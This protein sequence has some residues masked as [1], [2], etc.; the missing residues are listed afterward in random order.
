MSEPPDIFDQAAYDA[1]WTDIAAAVNK[2]GGINRLTV[3]V[4]ARMSAMWIVEVAPEKKTLNRI[5]EHAGVRGML[6]LFVIQEL[7]ERCGRSTKTR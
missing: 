1:A 6:D 5:H 7:R 4:M 3:V 2:H